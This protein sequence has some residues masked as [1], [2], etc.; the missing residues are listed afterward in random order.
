MDDLVRDLSS[1][2]TVLD[3]GAGGG[4]FS[5]QSTPARVIAVDVSFPSGSQ[6]CF[7][8]II[9][10]SEVIPLRNSSVDVAVC[11]HSLEH[12]EKPQPALLELNRV[13][14]PG[15]YL[16]VA[17]P[18]GFSF[19]DGLYRFLFRGGGHVNRF[20]FQSLVETIE[21]GTELRALRYKKLHSGFVYLNSPDPEKLI[22]YPSRAQT[23]ARVPRTALETMLRWM[24]YF[25]RLTDRWTGSSLSHYGW[26]AVFL[27]SDLGSQP[28]TTNLDQLDVIPPDIN[29][30][31]FCGAGHPIP[32][33][34]PHLQR[35]WLWK[36]Y[37]CRNCGK[38][39]L[40]FQ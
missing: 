21:S 16:W 7:A 5:Y 1:R 8:Q 26:G 32:T 11:N 27:R 38:E 15:G 25:V 20:S 13:I 31:F 39:N 10:S 6:T 29:V 23:L 36:V 24:N 14:K 34:L 30:C 2:S 35:Y 37:V 28:Q 22:H 4:S 17:V 18:D 33:L 9:A 19:D 12:F 3:L 40:F